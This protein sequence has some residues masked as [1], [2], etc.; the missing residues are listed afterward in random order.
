MKWWLEAWIEQEA[1]TV[2]AGLIT[3]VWRL[4]KYSNGSILQLIT[5]LSDGF[6]V[7]SSAVINT[8]TWHMTPVKHPQKHSHL[9]HE[10]NETPTAILVLKLRGV[11][12][13]MGS[14]SV[15]CYPTQVSRS[16]T[17]TTMRTTTILIA[18]WLLH[19]LQ[20]YTV[21]L[22]PDMETIT[23]SLEYPQSH[24]HIRQSQSLST[25]RRHLNIHYFQLAYPA[26]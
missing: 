5:H 4:N 6:T 14:H 26:T 17:T 16:T 12:C 18:I 10:T 7:T 15:T 23:I 24:L 20:H 22:S 2:R 8:L 25:F 19:P 9:T 11:T 13:H 1:V 3:T 21:T